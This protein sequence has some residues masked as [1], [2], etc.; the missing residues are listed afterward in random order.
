MDKKLMGLWIMYYEVQLLLREGLSYA[1]ISGA[2]V[3]NP[4]TVRKYAVMTED[5]YSCFLASRATRSKVLDT[6]EEFVK[7]KLQ[8][9]PSVKTAQMHDWLKE[10]HPDF[11]K[12][13]P[14]TV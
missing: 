1:A 14:K 10:H 5:G 7:A 2:L 4:R 13:P 9:H 11:P 12:V 8:A 6:Y 3:L